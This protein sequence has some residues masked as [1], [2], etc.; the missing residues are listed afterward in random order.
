MIDINNKPQVVF[1]LGP[2]GVGKTDLSIKLAKQFD[3]EIISADSVQIF[4]EFDI[5]SAKVTQEEMA[6]VTHYGIDIVS[7]KEE[8]SVSEFVDYTKNKIQ[9]ILSHNKLPIIVG[10]TAL[11]VKSLV[12]GYNFG[13]TEKHQEFRDNL[14]KEISE[15]GLESVYQRLQSLAPEIA[16]KTDGK[17]KVRVIRALEILQYGTEKTKENSVEYDYKI[18]ALTM[19]RELLYQRINKRAEI[20]VSRG[21]VEEVD[22][23]YGKYGKCQPMRAIG[24][25]EVVP[26]LKGEI[27]LEEM[28]SIISQHTRNYAKRQLTFLR[29]MQ[30]VNFVDVAQENEKERIFK[31]IEK[32]LRK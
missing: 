9:E 21:L 13:G 11:Y 5:G 29:G 2:T 4:K 7:P 16:Q 23:L 24:Y 19:P 32:W 14:E 6:G 25:K 26:Y 1:L 27:S 18:F 22:K 20:M 30:D 31:E 17:N 15:K 12:E 28:T 8:F 10:G 3:G